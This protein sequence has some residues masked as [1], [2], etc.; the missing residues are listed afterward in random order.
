MFPFP[1][2]PIDPDDPNLPEPLRSMLQRGMDRVAVI[3]DGQ[4]A[5]VEDKFN[6]F[7]QFL[8][9]MTAHQLATFREVVV[10]ILNSPQPTWLANR[11]EGQ[12]DAIQRMKYPELCR[13]CGLATCGGSSPTAMPMAE[14]FTLPP[15]PPLGEDVENIKAMFRGEPLVDRDAIQREVDRQAADAI[16]ADSARL[17][18]E[19]NVVPNPTGPTAFKCGNCG[20]DIVSLED[21]MRR[22]PGKGGC[23]GCMAKERH[24]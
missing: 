11:L 21:R 5:A 6:V 3:E 1:M 20:I 14:A 16:A 9:G 2:G 7:W 4:H 24:G 13:N 15:L 8:D 18:G 12:A 23:S 22:E 10:T 19:Y 17:M